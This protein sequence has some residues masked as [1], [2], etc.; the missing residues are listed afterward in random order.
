MNL[1]IRKIIKPRSLNEALLALAQ[2]SNAKPLAGGTDVIVQ[3]RDGRRQADVLIDLSQLGLT[4]ITERDGMIGIGA[5]M[6]MDAL[7]RNAFIRRALPALA[8]AAGQ[9]GAWTIQCR[10]TLG[11]NLG[12]AS[13]AADTAPAL[14]VADATVWTVAPEAA[15]RIPIDGF[16]TGPGKT[17]LRPDELIVSVHVPSVNLPDGARIVE[18]FVKVGARREQAIS[19]VS[20]AFR[21][22]V[23]KDGTLT[24]VRI[25][26][27]AV[28]PTP[29]RAKDTE[30]F[31]TGKMI[32]RDLQRKALIMMQKEIAP[33][34]DIRA[35]ARYRRLAAA[36]IFDR[37]LSEVIHG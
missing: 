9:V 28:A 31:L 2:N 32:D 17:M 4:V 20:G 23:A 15:R 8:T 37:F 22:I 13:P 29:V 18:R 11:G 26:F 25:A 36:V 3:L 1:P 5:G 10:A 21:V 7:A 19:M 27:G 24:S 34:D 16:F 6:T 33:I 30:H 14:L 12:N 35:T